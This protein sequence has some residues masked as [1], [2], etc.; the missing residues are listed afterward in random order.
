MKYASRLRRRARAMTPPMTPPAMAPGFLLVLGLGLL[1]SVCSEAGVEDDENEDVRVD[2]VFV[3]VDDEDGEPSVVLGRLEE[4]VM[5]TVP[6][7]VVVVVLRVLEEE[8]DEEDV[9]VK[10]LELAAPVGPGPALNAA[11]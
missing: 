10:E 4:A 6:V 2:E 7:L 1:V 5:V 3:S 8:E 11:I 9:V